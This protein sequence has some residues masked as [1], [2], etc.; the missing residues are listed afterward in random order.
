MKLNF[1]EM[2]SGI[3]IDDDGFFFGQ[4]RGSLLFRLE[5]LLLGNAG[6]L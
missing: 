6:L 3:N 5:V 1:F 4:T 2:E